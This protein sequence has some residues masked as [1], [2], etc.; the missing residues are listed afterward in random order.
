MKI[1]ARFRTPA[2]T[3]PAGWAAA[4]A[5]ALGYS[6]LLLRFPYD[7]VTLQW[8]FPLLLITPGLAT[9]ILLRGGFRRWY[10]WGAV[11]G[12]TLTTFPDSLQAILI[13][14]TTWALHRQWVTEA[15]GGIKANLRWHLTRT[16]TPAPVADKNF[17]RHSRKTKTA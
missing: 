7:P 17:N 16:A 5:V 1:P 11:A 14:G 12:L 3:T 15:T 9:M 4:L 10:R 8:L 13:I 6:I 2:W